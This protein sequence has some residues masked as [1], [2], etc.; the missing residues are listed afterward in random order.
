MRQ[1]K[2]AILCLQETHLTPEH[3]TQLEQLFGRRLQIVP[4]HPADYIYTSKIHYP[5]HSQAGFWR[6]QVVTKGAQKS[7][8]DYIM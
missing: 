6:T 7:C 3:V 5:R 2:I 4:S 1:K 8:D